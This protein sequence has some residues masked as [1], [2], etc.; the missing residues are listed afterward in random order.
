MAPQPTKGAGTIVPSAGV[1]LRTELPRV[2][3]HTT[4]IICS[5]EHC[6]AS[7]IPLQETA[8]CAAFAFAFS[9][10]SFSLLLESL[11]ALGTERLVSLALEPFCLSL[12]LGLAKS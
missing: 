10:F 11:L 8:E 2:P 7:C 6:H 4:F 12:A 3:D 5:R 9:T 1:A